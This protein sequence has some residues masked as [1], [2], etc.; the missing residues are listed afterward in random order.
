MFF[1]TKWLKRRE[2]RRL[3]LEL[4][5]AKSSFASRKEAMFHPN[6][7]SMV[8]RMGGGPDRKYFEDWIRGL[9]DRIR[10]LQDALLKG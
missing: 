8:V 4:A 9:E 7:D 3:E 6:A 5:E 10:P 2:L 1:L